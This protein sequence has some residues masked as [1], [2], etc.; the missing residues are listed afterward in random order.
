M[1][2]RVLQRLAPHVEENLGH[3]GHEGHKRERN[4]AI[5]ASL[6]KERHKTQQ[7]QIHLNSCTPTVGSASVACWRCLTN[8][9]GFQLSTY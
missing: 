8:I 2:V 1:G 4:Q 9:S 7:W 5:C 3:W 6:R